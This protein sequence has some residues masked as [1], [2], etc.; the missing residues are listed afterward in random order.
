MSKYLYVNGCSYTAGNQLKLED[1]WTYKLGELFKDRT[2][3]NKSV[4]GNSMFTICHTTFHHLQQLPPE[5]TIVVVGCTW[6]GR[7]AF[8]FEDTSINITPS[9]TSN[10][11]EKDNFYDKLYK[12]RRISVAHDL[13]LNTKIQRDQSDRY[14][15]DDKMKDGIITKGNAGQLKN[16]NEL[17]SKYVAFKKD[18]IKK[19]IH[20]L[21]NIQLEYKYHLTMLETY[22]KAKGYKYLFVDFQKYYYPEN[23]V[24]FSYTK[25]ET[26]HPTAEDCTKYANFIYNKLT[27]E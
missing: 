24:S 5:D 3:I 13:D 27:N 17:C 25:N 7:D 9:D 11:Y 26:S 15:P 23:F 2:L 6:E 21:R 14:N 12:W 4:N 10:K 18:L 22:L 16:F 19:D 8:L 1:T 20:Y